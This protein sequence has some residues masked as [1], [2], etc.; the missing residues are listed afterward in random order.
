MVAKTTQR[1]IKTPAQMQ[2]H[3]V[4]YCA[5][6]REIVAAYVFGSAAR[7]TAGPLSDLDI[8]FLLDRRR[9]RLSDSLAYQAARLSDL[10]ALL[11]TDRVDLVLLPC[12]SPLLEHRILRDGA[13][14]YCRDTRQRLAFEEKALRTYLD[15]KPF[16]ERQTRWFFERHR[17][18][19]A[20]RRAGHG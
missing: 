9:T 7:G 17:A 6:R 10:M 8:A 19:Q 13:V 3:V 4:R 18:A 12:T 11:R 1:D 5:K 2:D 15:L 20:R 14:L 16:Y